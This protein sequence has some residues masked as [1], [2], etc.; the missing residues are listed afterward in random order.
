MNHYCYVP[1]A[2]AVPAKAARPQGIC[3]S[4]AEWCCVG[5][6]GGGGGVGDGGGGGWGWGWAR[7]PP[8][9]PH[10]CA[11]SGQATSLR[12]SLCGPQGDFR[13]PSVSPKSSDFPAMIA[14][15]RPRRY[16]RCWRHRQKMTRTGYRS[17]HSCCH[18]CCPEILLLSVMCSQ[19]ACCRLRGGEW[20]PRSSRGCGVTWSWRRC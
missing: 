13:S 6:G 5:S 4:S 8:S 17:R 18:C 15:P 14:A 3:P 7:R 2:A 1:V 11:L 10:P 19:K 9:Q 16:C 20:P 12:Q